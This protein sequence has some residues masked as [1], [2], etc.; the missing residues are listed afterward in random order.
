VE[1]ARVLQLV[2]A[3]EKKS[4]TDLLRPVLEGYAKSL[5]KEQEVARML[6]QADKWAERK[7]GVAPIGRKTRRKR[8]QSSPRSST[9]E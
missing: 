2:A 8:T 3:A 4:M 5:V 7:S 1:D 9:G 6:E